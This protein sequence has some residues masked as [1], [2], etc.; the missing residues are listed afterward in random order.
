[1]ELFKDFLFRLAY[2]YMIVLYKKEYLIYK[3][4]R[5]KLKGIRMQNKML[6]VN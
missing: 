6:M 2:I 5:T 1:M 4:K 3:L